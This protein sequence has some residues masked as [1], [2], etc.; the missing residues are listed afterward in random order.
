MNNESV[1]CLAR[2]TP[3][4]C[5]LRLHAQKESQPVKV[6]DDKDPFE[7]FDLGIADLLLKPVQKEVRKLVILQMNSF[8]E[9]AIFFSTVFLKNHEIITLTIF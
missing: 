2:F 1:H 6:F 8:Y 9:F 7:V 3:N 4:D 5:I